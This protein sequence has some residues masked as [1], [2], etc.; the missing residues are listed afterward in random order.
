MIRSRRSIVFHIYRVCF[1]LIVAAALAAT[2][3]DRTLSAR[4]SAASGSGL[5]AALTPIH[6]IVTVG[7]LGTYSSLTNAGGL[8]EAMNT[9]GVDGDLT[10]LI[11][12]DLSGEQGA[13]LMPFAPPFT[14]TIKS[15]GPARIIQGTG[16]TFLIDLNGA[17]R[18][19]LDGT[20]GG[21]YGLTFRNNG[22]GAHFSSNKTPRTTR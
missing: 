22:P 20:V 15:D 12:S 6:G 19:T 3:A 2:N 17:D 7:A 1:F 4:P 9:Q 10:A 16:A 8:F 5:G 11:V 21:P 18:V 14:F 13:S